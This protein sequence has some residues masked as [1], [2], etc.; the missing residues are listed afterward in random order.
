MTTADA[1]SV[2]VVDDDAMV[3]RSIGQNL[4]L[5]GFAPTVATSADEALARLADD[6]IDVVLT[7]LRM[8]GRDGLALLEAIRALRPATPVLMLTGHGDVPLAV[9]A[10]K[11]G[12]YDFLT[13]PHDPDRLAVALRNAGEQRRLSRR[14]AQ[15]EAERA[16]G[17]SLDSVLIGHSPAI[18]ALRERIRAIAPLPVDVLL[19]GETGTGKEVVAHALHDESP[20][21]ARPFVAVNCAAIPAELVESELFGH[22]AGAFSGAR[23]GGRVGKFEFAQGGTLF[24]DELESM[25]L[26]QQGKVL[27]AL[28]ERTIERVGSNRTIKVDLRV[29]AAAKDDLRAA[30]QAGT[31]RDDLYYRLAGV[32]LAIPPL[33]DRPGDAELLFQWFA[34]AKAREA[35]RPSPTLR[36]E[37]LHAVALHSWPGNV[38]ELRAA[39]E[40]FALGLG[41]GLGE[42]ATTVPPSAA[43]RALPDLVENFER[44]LIAM[45]LR[46]AGGS[47]AAAL[48]ELGIPRRTLNEKLRKYGIRRSDFSAGGEADDEEAG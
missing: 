13:K 45:A 39:A 20:R 40:R 17:R 26:A 11:A 14:V 29:I 35:G 37:E 19:H 36:L 33:R 5:R 38:R 44:S 21:R 7:D 27:R 41:L 22:E 43:A 30:M 24:L 8:P 34:L 18:V 2:L 4:G 9:A 1:L 12:A 28:Q 16:D 42:S 23:Q 47:V 46:R 32:V 48:A 15:L 31:L 6:D 3:A 25:P 10:L